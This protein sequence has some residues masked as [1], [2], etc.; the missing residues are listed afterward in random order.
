MINKI[1]PSSSTGY[2][3]EVNR[4]ESKGEV[5][6]PKVYQ[7]DNTSAQ[8]SLSGDAQA[9]QRVFQAVKDTPD[10]RVD[11][12]EAVRDKLNT[13]TYQVNVETLAERLLPLL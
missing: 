6:R 8:V 12:V 7:I 2:T 3:N 9:L 10:I 4:L 13:G 11:V 5:A 1:Q